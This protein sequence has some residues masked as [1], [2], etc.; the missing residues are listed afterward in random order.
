MR[1]D[2]GQEEIFKSLQHFRSVKVKALAK[3]WSVTTQTICRDLAELRK[4]ESAVRTY[5]GAQRI[6][7]KT[8]VAYE[9]RRLKNTVTKRCLAEAE[10][11]LVP[12]GASLKLNIGTTTEMVAAALHLHDVLKVIS[13]NIQVFQILK[14]SRIKSLVLKGDEI[15]LFNYAVI[16]KDAVISISN[17]KVDLAIIGASSIDKDCSILDFDQREVSVSRSNLE[18]LRKKILV[19]DVSEFAV[20]ADIKISKTKELDYEILNEISPPGF[21]FILKDH[22]T[23]PIIAKDKNAILN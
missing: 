16:E 17:S 10:A 15:R 23:Q 6:N 4:T 7:I 11:D 20:P 22:D 18:N 12:Y 19:A 1:F 13:N 8:V 2:D 14:A 5:G 3:Q 21:K 9:D